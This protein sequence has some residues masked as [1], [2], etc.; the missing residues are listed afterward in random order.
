[1]QQQS[2][3]IDQGRYGEPRQ[4]ANVP[5]NSLKDSMW[6]CPNDE[7]TNIGDTCVICGQKRPEAAFTPVLPIEQ[8]EYT[9]P[10]V[11]E[12]SIT[13]PIWL[14]AVAGILLAVAL[15]FVF[16]NSDASNSSSSSAPTVLATTPT[17][18]PVSTP[19]A[20][21][22]TNPSNTSPSSDFATEPPAAQAT[23]PYSN[24]SA[25]DT[26]KI[27]TF[28][29]DGV[30]SNG[31]ETIE[32]VVLDV[33]NGEALLI[34]KN[35]LFCGQYNDVWASLGWESCT[36]RTWLNKSFYK[37]VFTTNEQKYI[38]ESTVTAE[39]NPQ[40]HTSAGND[41]RDKVFVLSISEAERYLSK[42][43]LLKGHATTNANQDGV[44]VTSSGLS[45]YW[46]RSPGEDRTTA[47]YVTTDGTI[48]KKGQAFTG[49]DGGVRPA[50]RIS[51]Y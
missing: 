36:L 19:S 13:K 1:M 49:G 48:N 38:Q 15:F 8:Y 34:S 21:Q 4:S 16:S 31:A 47:A 39:S 18:S 29:Q 5:Q 37:S 11:Q 3:P 7:T 10:A 9:A 43:D 2:S 27:G 30:T 40:Y 45:W 41:T 33:Q 14:I 25:G 28:E 50:I 12:K 23:N 44:R 22:A 46:L 17:S 32:W 42:N 24:L 20:T 35:I 6:V 51:V 26:V